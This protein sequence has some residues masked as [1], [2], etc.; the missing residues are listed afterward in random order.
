M[1]FITFKKVKEQRNPLTDELSGY[2][3]D[4][5]IYVP[6]DE[7]NSYYQAVK[8]YIE[9]GGVV[10]PAYS[11][12]DVKNIKKNEIKSAFLKASVEPITV[13]DVTWNGGYESATKIN[14]AI[15][16]AQAL[17]QETVILYDIENKPHEMS[18]AD[19]QNV[20]IEIGK[21]YQ[22]DLAKKQSLYAEIEEATTIDELKAINWN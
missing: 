19:A 4:D 14:G 13:N 7:S 17:G 11:L 8:K 18:L 22:A 2:I 9:D 20:V 1:E 21:K 3:V 6:I 5:G 15:Q 10:E 12:D 16:L